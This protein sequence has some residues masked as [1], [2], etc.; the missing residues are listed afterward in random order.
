[1]AIYNRW[2]TVGLRVLSAAGHV[3]VT[4]SVEEAIESLRRGGFGESKRRPLCGED[5]RCFDE[6]GADDAGFGDTAL[7]TGSGSLVGLED[8]VGVVFG[9]LGACPFVI[10]KPAGFV[11]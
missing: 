3:M 1:V 8:V 11:L 2:K 6:L 7:A 9:S 5:F 4:Y 10:S